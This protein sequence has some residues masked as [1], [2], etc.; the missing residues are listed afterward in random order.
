MRMKFSVHTGCVPR[1]R[2]ATSGCT[3]IRRAPLPPRPAGG[4]Q[5]SCAPTLAR[6]E[7]GALH[8]CDLPARHRAD[9]LLCRRLAAAA[10]R[11]LR[12]IRRDYGR[13]TS[14]YVRSR[15]CRIPTRSASNAARR[16]LRPREARLLERFPIGVNHREFPRG[17]EYSVVFSCRRSRTRVKPFAAEGPQAMAARSGAPGARPDAGRDSPPAD[18]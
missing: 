16:L 8:R 7:A 3:T 10:V 11:C 17:A 12:L 14:S 2:T 13:G 4:S 18:R 9:E 6:A 1:I 5:R 15:A